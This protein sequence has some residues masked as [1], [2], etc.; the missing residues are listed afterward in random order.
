MSERG[1]WVIR[2]DKLI[3]KHLAPPLNP[4]HAEGPMVINGS[5]DDVWNPVNGKRYS[6]KR[7]YEKDVA[8]AGCTIIGN[9]Q[10]R[11]SPKPMDDPGHDLKQAFEIAEAKAPKPKRAK[12]RKA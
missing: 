10:M 8:R 5:L 12:K 3:P 6:C 1:V 9:E 11:A 2:N 7:A 4:R